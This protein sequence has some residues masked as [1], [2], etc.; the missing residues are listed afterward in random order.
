MNK[1]QTCDV[2]Q[3]PLYYKI[4]VFA[5][6]NKVSIKTLHHYD[7][8]GLLKPAYVDANNGYRY[9]TSS[10]LP[11]LHHILALR[12]IDFSL[13]EIKS[14]LN[15][16]SEEALLR[17][18]KQELSDQIYDRMKQIA[19]IES[20]L[21]HANHQPLPHVVIKSLPEVTVARM[22]VELKAYE[23][24]FDWMPKFGMEM[25]RCG[26]VCALPDYCFTL[27]EEVDDQD[28]NVHA[29]LCQA[30]TKIAK[31]SEIVDC[32]IMPEVPE[33]ACMYHQGAYTD[34]P[35]TYQALIAYIEE[36]GYEMI[37]TPRECYIDGIWNKEN[38][39]DWL[40]EIQIPVKKAL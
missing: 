39:K 28:A 18:K 23:E 30:V 33:A 37:G 5:Q 38:Q 1:Q 29:V 17:N 19:S 32:C 7:E 26:C 25:E 2:L 8:I 11:D 15:G 4:G 34:F 3:P 24:L 40:S 16:A 13:E 20:Y 9:Y 21:V 36:N 22:H 12:Q 6:L 10:Q 31:E 14:V 27:Y 35:K